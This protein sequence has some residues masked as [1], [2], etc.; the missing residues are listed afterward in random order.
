[1]PTTSATCPAY[2]RCW[3]GPAA[4]GGTTLIEDRQ[5]LPA[6]AAG[7]AGTR[8]SIAFGK[9]GGAL[10]SLGLVACWWRSCRASRRSVAAPGAPLAV[11]VITATLS[12]SGSPQFS[13]R[14]ASIALRAGAVAHFRPILPGDDPA[15]SDARA[16]QLNPLTIM[17]V[18][19]GLLGVQEFP[20][21][22]RASLTGLPASPSGLALDRR[23]GE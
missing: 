10:A 18:A 22:E 16:G 21:A 6:R 7:G 8:A 2:W 3:V 15:G 4:G 13:Q 5:R 17:T 9:L 23:P 20:G 14:R 19:R 11:I 12:R 1:V